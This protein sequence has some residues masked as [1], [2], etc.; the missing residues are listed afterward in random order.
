MLMTNSTNLPRRQRGF[1]M[2]EVLVALVVFSL[3]VLG[4]IRLQAT[5]VRMST[6][7]RQRAEA[8]F[9]ADQLLA[10][11]LIA[12]PSTAATFAHRPDGSVTCAPTGTA[13]ANPVVTEWLTQ[14]TATFPR[15][16]AAEQ[17]V[18]VATGAATDVTVRMCWKNADTDT[19]HTFEI[20]NRVQWP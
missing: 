19:P 11:L 17:Q 18:V 9:L 7:A 20:T 8:T 10:R 6:D 16:L 3:G 1:S 5:A 15:A 4:L 2:V 12:D 14:V 13:S